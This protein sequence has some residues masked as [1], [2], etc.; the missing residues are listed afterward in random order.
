MVKLSSIAK[1]P[2]DMMEL[3]A[4]ILHECDSVYDTWLPSLLQIL[5]DDETGRSIV[6]TKKTRCK[7]A[8]YWPLCFCVDV[9]AKRGCSLKSLT[10]EDAELM[11]EA[12]LAEPY[13]MSQAKHS[14]A[15]KV[16]CF[17]LRRFSSKASQHQLEV[18]RKAL[19]LHGPLD[20]QGKR[21]PVEVVS[22]MMLDEV[23][24]MM[25]MSKEDYSLARVAEVD[26]DE[27]KDSKKNSKEKKAR[28]A[29]SRSPNRKRGS[30]RRA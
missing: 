11:R 7:L 27:G 19:I 15:N 21:A 16:E 29:I 9:G 14:V 6:L 1:N 30:R 25:T 4:K 10:L 12:S 26:E 5:K 8:A 18:I 22:D 28:Q 24:R 3:R 2:E 13:I 17:F 23:H 20:K